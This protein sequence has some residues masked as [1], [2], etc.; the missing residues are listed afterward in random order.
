[1]IVLWFKV[2]PLWKQQTKRL[3][4]HHL[5]LIWR[6]VSS[7]VCTPQIVCVMFMKHVSSWILLWTMNVIFLFFLLFLCLSSLTGCFCCCWLLTTVCAFLSLLIDTFT[8]FPP[9]FCPLSVLSSLHSFSAC[10]SSFCS[11]PHS[12]LPFH[13]GRRKLV[14]CPQLLDVD[15]MVKLREP[16]WKCVYTYLQEFYRG[17]VTKGLVKTKNS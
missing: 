3:N 2:S 6:F 17:L 1:M 15:D 5:M 4:Q 14:D 12:A 10:G 16:D 8:L 7:R 9:L 11:S 13:R